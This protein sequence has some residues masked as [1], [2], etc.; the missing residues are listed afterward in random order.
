M[1]Q[2]YQKSVGEIDITDI[3]FTFKRFKK[4]I[5][6]FSFI[7]FFLGGLLALNTKKVWQGEFQIVLEEKRDNIAELP[8]NFPVLTQGKSKLRTQ[9]EILKSPSLL[10]N[11]FEFVK[12]NKINAN[13]PGSKNLKF[14]SWRNNNLKFVLTEKTSVLNISYQDTNKDLIIKV[15]DDISESYQKYSNQKRER[16]IEL[17]EKYL[18]EQ[19]NIFKVKSIDSLRKSQEFAMDNQLTMLNDAE[20]DKEIPNV[21]NLDQIRIENAAKIK[22]ID[23]QIS[24]LNK[25]GND[26]TKLLYFG[27]L[28]DGLKETGLPSKLRDIE[29]DLSFKRLIFKEEDEAIKTLIQRKKILIPILKKQAL[30]ILN[31]KKIDAQTRLKLAERPKGTLIKYYQLLNNSIKDKA[32]LNN[33][34]DNYRSTLLEKNIKKDPWSLITSPTLYPFPIEPRI[35]LYLLMG[36]LL[37]FSLGCIYA[38]WLDKNKDLIFRESEFSQISSSDLIQK[39]SLKNFETWDQNLNFISSSLINKYSGQTLLLFSGGIDEIYIN[40]IDEKFKKYNDKNEYKISNNIIDLVNSSSVILVTACGKTKR[41]DLENLIKN[42]SILD[43]PI[44]GVIILD[45]IN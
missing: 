41:S 28:I 40:K 7:G 29:D 11:I 30:A 23:M 12:S 15:L 43:L 6:I 34:E 17:T 21:I 27:R 9:I 19:I 25:L 32:T 16:R 2:I 3:L 39:L 14:K 13:E 35:K 45:I 4:I 10:M 38:I 22:D 36:L 20:I 37:G 31:S 44:L 42:I 5:F 26:S 8:S 1:N 33:L 18:V 24:Q